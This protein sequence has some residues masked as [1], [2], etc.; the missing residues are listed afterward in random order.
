MSSV[1]IKLKD[2]V[3]HG[4]ETIKEL[5]IRKPKAKDLKEMP[6]MNQNIGH[7]LTMASNLS[8]QPPSVI[9]ELSIPDMQEV[10]AVVQ[11]FIEG[12]PQTGKGS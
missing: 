12:S 4:S 5:E 8:G 2:P 7:F 3:S 1:K 10:V 11:N 6:L 9:E